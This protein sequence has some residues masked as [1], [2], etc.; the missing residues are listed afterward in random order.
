MPNQVP[1]RTSNP[2]RSTPGLK[3]KHQDYFNELKTD[4]NGR[5]G[6]CNSFDQ[7]RNNDFEVDHYV[8]RRVLSTIRHNDYFNL[9]YS[10][11]SCNRSKSGKW[12][13]NDEMIHLVGN[14]GFVD[15]ADPNYSS[16]FIRYDFGEIY[17]VTPNGKWMYEELSLFHDQHAV[18]WMLEKIRMAI[19]EAR[20]KKTAQPTNPIVNDALIALFEIQE[21]YLDK[22]FNV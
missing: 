1:F 14:T 5:C 20:Q 18:S 17:W 9:V 19:E 3:P 7:R 10:C 6:Y 13:S 4:F 12:P 11:K 8:P 16:H 15:P 22:L 21:T 2:V